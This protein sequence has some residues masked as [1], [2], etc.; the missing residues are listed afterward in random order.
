MSADPDVEAERT[1]AHPAARRRGLGQTSARSLLLTLLGELVLPRDEPV[2]TQV[3]IDVLAGL[4]VESKS[5]RQAL[6]RTA[7]EGLIRSDRAGHRVR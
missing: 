1:G 3:L 5:A 4:G 2:W 7:A 6:A